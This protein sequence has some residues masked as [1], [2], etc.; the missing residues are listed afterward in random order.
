MF[1]GKERF[2]DGKKVMVDKDKGRKKINDEK[3]VIEKG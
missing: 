1:K 2:K 3:I